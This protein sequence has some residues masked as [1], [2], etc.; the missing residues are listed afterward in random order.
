MVDT[1][2]TG[3]S[4]VDYNEALEMI[5]LVWPVQYKL[6]LSCMEFVQVR[7][8]F[9]IMWN[10]KNK[11]DLKNENDIKNEDDITNEN[12]IKNEDNLKKKTT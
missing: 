1:I 8:G 11:D 6:G 10:F 7:E 2:D 5:R 4:L 3:L 12:D 9:K